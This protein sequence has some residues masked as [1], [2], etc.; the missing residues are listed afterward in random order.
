M[1]LHPGAP[2][3]IATSVLSLLNTYDNA[4]LLKSIVV[5]LAL[6][7]ATSDRCIW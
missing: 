4:N 7:A 2:H 5:I 1:I 6:E 3:E